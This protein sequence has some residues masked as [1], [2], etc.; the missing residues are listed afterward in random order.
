VHAHIHVPVALLGGV[1]N[2]AWSTPS[3]GCGFAVG[4]AVDVCSDDCPLTSLSPDPGAFTKYMCAC[5]QSQFMWINQSIVEYH[6]VFV[7]Y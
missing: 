2:R 6:L 3:G 7:F 5:V 4:A 1:F